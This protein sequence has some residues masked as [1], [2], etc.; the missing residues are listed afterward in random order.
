MLT[1]NNS[2]NTLITT[3]LQQVYN[4]LNNFAK[5]D[6]FLA[7]V[8]SIFGTN[9]DASKLEEIRQQWINSNFTSLP[10]IEIRSGLELQE[11]N[12]V[13]AGSN[14]T[15]Y[16]SQDFLTK[17]TNNPQAIT[18]VL[19]EEIGHSVD[20]HI[21]TGDTP[22]DEGEFFSNVVQGINLTEGQIKALQTEND[23]VLLNLNNSGFEAPRDEEI[24]QGDD[25]STSQ[26]QVLQPQNDSVLA[27]F[28]GSLFEVEQSFEDETYSSKNP[29]DR[30]EF[31]TNLTKLLIFGTTAPS[32]PDY[33]SHI[34]DTTTSLFSAEIKYDMT[35]YMNNGGGRYAY[36]SRFKAVEKFFNSTADLPSGQYT[37]E[38]KRNKDEKREIQNTSG[39]SEKANELLSKLELTINDN[40]DDFSASVNQYL[41]GIGSDDHAERAYIFGSTSFS[42]ASITFDIS[43]SGTKTIKDMEVR[44]FKDN[45]D[46]NSS[47]E[48][49]KLLSKIYLKPRF[50]P[51]DLSLDRGAIEIVFNE[52][53]GKKS[54]N[55]GI[56]SFSQD[57]A[58]E[59]I[60]FA[61][62]VDFSQYFP[63][64]D[65]I[66]SDP[67]LS[68]YRNNLKVIYG[69]PQGESLFYGLAVK[70]ISES[71]PSSG[72]LI[73]GGKENDNLVGDFFADEIQGGDG[74]DYG[75]GRRGNDKFYGSS[76]NDTYD[77][78]GSIGGILWSGDDY[79]EG[80]SGNDK[81][82]GADG[83]DAAKGG[84]ENDQLFGENGNDVLEGELG[85][86]Y[87]EGGS[88]D[89]KYYGG[90]GNDLGD[91]DGGNGITWSG[92]DYFEGGKGNDTFYGAD[93]NDMAYGGEGDDFIRGENGRD[94][95]YGGG[96]NDNIGGGFHKDSRWPGETI[97]TMPTE[98]S[99]TIAGL[100]V[101]AEASTTRF[102]ANTTNTNSTTKIYA[103]ANI[104]TQQEDDG[105]DLIYGGKG[106][107]SIAG[108][109]GKD[110]IFGDADNDL[111]LGG[112]GEDKISGGSDQDQVFGGKGNDTISGNDGQDTL[113]G[114]AGN[115]FLSGNEGN[116]T[117]NG[118]TEQDELYGELGN[119]ILNG[120]GGDDSL[121]GQEGN[122]I[123]SGGTDQDELYGGD[124]EDI[125][126]GND[127]Q[128]TLYGGK[129]QDQL[130]G[131]AGN[132][133]L[134]GQDD[135]DTLS[136]GIDQD[137]L[138][139]GKGEDSL[140]GDAGNDF[141]YR[142][143]QKQLK[144]L[145]N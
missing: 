8:Q 53:E 118:G 36:P 48:Y 11:A 49:S 138:Y 18:S 139:G 28:N 74:N 9:F 39:D 15:I 26:I 125:L 85:D 65:K 135:Q 140:N 44:A 83:N 13:Y 133:S 145:C 137:T 6:D 101:D 7:K 29:I 116:D 86:D 111:I 37:Y 79:F 136:G 64:L 107:D 95:I 46:F 131:D 34:R 24:L 106:N 120:D 89:D 69:T 2:L 51:Y 14:N 57:Q 124:N 82:Y 123:L 143:L 80:N 134:L 109:E 84:T 12:A 142:H 98:A 144:P 45:F 113:S 5:G 59:N 67:F 90:D 32:S 35:D 70:P 3:S 38:V 50:D 119:D 94:T 43:E 56:F 114:D 72:Y 20:W 42:L 99:F 1:S 4:S 73:V 47:D 121:F 19:L 27:N 22:G 108:D 77:D 23:S 61:G 88:D 129:G 17:Y 93:G 40:S 110:E 127:G 66:A 58:L 81:F 87:L 54:S 71:S 92:H 55:Y 91:D 10:P 128:D 122:D 117:L 97:G 52:G 30:N 102:A 75:E 112:T 104:Q 78:D 21:N 141:L 130:N 68:Y 115:D 41:T 16:V 103:E 63:Y 100:G 33:N 62:G 105:D 31:A 96:E 132:D 25:L 126:N 76:G 60:D